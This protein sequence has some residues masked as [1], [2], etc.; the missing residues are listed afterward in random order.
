MLGDGQHHAVGPWQHAEPG[1]HR[2]PRL[3]HGTARV[4]EDLVAGRVVERRVGVHP[5]DGRGV[6]LRPEEA[7]SKH[8]RLGLDARDLREADGMGLLG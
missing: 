2:R 1:R 7:P 8:D 6:V 3:V 5:L 4:G